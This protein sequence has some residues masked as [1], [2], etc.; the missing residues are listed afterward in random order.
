MKSI[1]LFFIL[2]SAVACNSLAQQSERVS[3][4][5]QTISVN[6]TG[7]V[8]APADIIQLQVAISIYNQSAREAF[9]RHKQQ[10]SFLTDLLID[11]GIDDENIRVQPVS[12]NPGR[13]SSNRD[14]Y[15]TRQQVLVQLTDIE[16]FQTI[17]LILIENGFDNFSGSFSSSEMDTA[18]EDAVKL[19]VEEAGKKAGLIAGEAGRTLGE[20]L[21]IEY[22]S[23]MPAVYRSERLSMDMS[24]GGSLLQ[25]E[26]TVPVR[27]TVQ[28]VY[29]LN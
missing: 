18:Q 19:A 13:S 24:S 20:V 25:F 2:F 4:D 29:R 23:S 9:N 16:Q 6:A 5:Y 12:I 8:Q 22:G 26:Q 10:E 11:E 7:E 21:R 15:E 14:G 28:I 17:Q 1:T 3:S 27:E